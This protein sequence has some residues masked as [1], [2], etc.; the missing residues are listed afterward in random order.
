MSALAT[1]SYQ[2]LQADIGQLETFLSTLFRY[3]DEGTYISFR[4]FNQWDHGKPPILIQASSVTAMGPASLAVEAAVAA[5]KICRMN[6]VFAPPVAPFTNSDR[7]RHQDT[8]NGVAISVELD[9]APSA[10]RTFLEG[11]LGPVTLAMASGSTWIDDETG[12]EQAKLHLHWRLSEPTAS[13]EDH[14][15]LRT[16]RWLAASLVGGDLTAPPPCHPLRWPG[17]WNIKRAPRMAQIVSLNEAVE[18]HLDDALER[19]K[20]AFEAKGLTM[21]TEAV[22]REPG[23]L[24]A[25][26]ARIASAMTAV[27]N[28]KGWDEWI[29]VGLALWNATGACDEGFELWDQWSQKSE[30]YVAASCVERWNHF[31]SHP[32]RTVGAQTIFALA[33]EN[34]W[35]KLRIFSGANERAEMEEPPPIDDTDLDAQADAAIAAQEAGPEAED[36]R[37]EKEAKAE[38]KR[39]FKSMLTDFN[40]RYMVVNENGKAIVYEPS[41]DPVLK[42]RRFDRITFEDLNRLY[43]NQQVVIGVD[44]K[45]RPIQ[46]SKA[47]LWLK[48]EQRRQYIGGVRFDPSEQ[49]GRDVLNLWEGFAVEPRP[50][51]WSLLRDHV[52][53]I[54]CDGDEGNFQYLMGWMARM[55]QFP[56]E[57]GE[58]AVVMKGGEG[59]GKGF[60]AKALLTIMGQHGIAISNTRH[61]IGNFNAHLRD[62]ILLF[63]DEAFFAGDKASTG[64]LKS[65]I[66]EPYLTIEGKFQN[67]TQMPNFLHVMMA[68]NEE[69]VVPASQDARRFFVLEVSEARKQDLDYFGA[70][71]DQLKAGGYEGMLHDLLERDITD[72]R[73]RTVP[74]TTG[75]QGQRKLSLPTTEAWWQDCLERGYVLKSKLGLEE[76]FAQW[77]EI[78][79]MELLFASYLDFAEKRRERHPLSREYLGRFMKRMGCLATRPRKG[80]GGEHIV[81]EVNA[82]GHSHRV[83]RPIDLT[84]PPSY[85]LGNL[86]AARAGFASATGLKVDWETKASFPDA[87]E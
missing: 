70:I 32:P 16:A 39:A 79:S 58:V 82:F 75:L 55:V 83:A 13:M 76:H 34:G 64:V 18:V 2:E 23:E 11:L 57:Q 54:I 33:K 66:T 86:E 50:G 49:C 59:T 24:Q 21:P 65:L 47:Q 7:A 27:P 84:Q 9:A 74:I 3:A 37:R 20:A 4:G 19:L 71:M 28:T 25:P 40:G 43:L 26:I 56:A 48:H 38:R 6:G 85:K 10:G 63:A 78:A 51:D 29:R 45:G 14:N 8:A 61:L 35:G 81:D 15:R 30:K 87:A 60:L 46:R 41:F 17:S 80:L 68:S 69:W 31:A 77:I 1:T 36:E 67:A 5:N 62:A 52:R 42:R 12:E 44:E 72:F 53:T 73:V 22:K